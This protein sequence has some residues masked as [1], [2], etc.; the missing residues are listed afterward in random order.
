MDKEVHK[1]IMAVVAKQFQMDK[2]VYDYLVIN[3]IVPDTQHE[4]AIAQIKA[5]S[6]NNV[7]EIAAFYDSLEPDGFWDWVGLGMEKWGKIGV[8]KLGSGTVQ[9][10]EYFSWVMEHGPHAPDNFLAHYNSAMCT[11]GKNQAYDLAFSVHFLVDTGTPFHRKKIEDIKLPENLDTK[12]DKLR[13]I[14][15]VTNFL[16]SAF[17]IHRQH[18]NDFRDGWFTSKFSSI[19]NEA[20]N[21]GIKDSLSQFDSL[22]VPDKYF[23]TKIHELAEFSYEKCIEL[24]IEYRKNE[25]PNKN[26][27]KIHEISGQCLYEISKLTTDVLS[28]FFQ[29]KIGKIL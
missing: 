8:E 27:I 10:M 4:D 11:S 25:N 5:I 26:N 22:N 14:S 13:A 28:C 24:E 17:L 7:A 29:P 2:I 16:D 12:E 1:Q 3:T 21:R 18:E 9:A 6:S 23:E 20:I 15:E 19:Y